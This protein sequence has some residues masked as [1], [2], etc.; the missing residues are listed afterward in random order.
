MIGYVYGNEIILIT[1]QK[2]IVI[3]MRD[4]D[5]EQEQLKNL[6]SLEIL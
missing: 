2:M 3:T 5:E 6:L 1:M 4:C